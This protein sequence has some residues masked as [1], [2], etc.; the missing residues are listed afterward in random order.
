MRVVRYLPSPSLQSYVRCFMTVESTAAVPNRVLPTTS[1]VLAVQYRGRVQQVESGVSQPLPP[2][3][4]TGM[5]RAPRIL[6]YA[7]N[8]AT[9]LAHFT[10]TGAA[11]FFPQPLHELFGTSLPLDHLLPPAAVTA[12]TERVAT[13]ASTGQRLAVLGDFLLGRLRSVSATGPIRQALHLIQAAGG[14][15]SIRGVVAGLPV[16]R[17]PFEKQFRQLVG[18]SPKQFATLV[19]L[20]WVLAHHADAT[21]LTELA[22]AAGYFDQAHFNKAFK[23]FT[24]QAAF[25]AGGAYW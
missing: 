24:G 13:A 10:E 16:S 6:A 17:D 15:A 23:A 5:S 1:L 9:L 2:A 8:T 20:R 19:R 18:T 22:H 4:L 3:A 7:P 21:S 11:A 12:L 14:S 25:F